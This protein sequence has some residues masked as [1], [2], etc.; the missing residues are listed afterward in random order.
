MVSSSASRV[1]TIS[2]RPVCAGGGD[3]GAEAR[4]LPVAR[5][6]VVEV[7]EAALADG[8]DLGFGG[9]LDQRGRVVEPL[10][11]GLVRMDAH[12]ADHARCRRRP[13]PRTTVQPPRFVAM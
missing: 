13:G 2:G 3:V 6:E 10:L 9:E 7:V 4:R 8:D 12:G 11:A 5:G 1:W